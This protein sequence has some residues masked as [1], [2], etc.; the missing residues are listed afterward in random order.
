[1][2]YSSPFRNFPIC[3]PLGIAPDDSVA[4]LVNLFTMTANGQPIKDAAAIVTSDLEYP[5]SGTLHCSWNS[6]L[7]YFVTGVQGRGVQDAI[8]GVDRISGTTVFK[9]EMPAGIYTDNLMYDYTTDALYYFAFNI[10]Q[11]PPT[12]AIVK[13]DA[14]TGNITYIFDVSREIKGFVYGGDVTICPTTGQIFVGVD[15]EANDGGFNDYIVEF[16]VTGALPTIVGGRPLAF[17]V[18]SGMHAFCNA[19]GLQFLVGDTIQADSLDRETALVGQFLIPQDGKAPIV[20]VPFIS[21]RLPT[22]S[23]RGEIPLFLDSQFSEFQ[24]QVIIPMFPPFQ[25]GPGPAP[26]IIGGLVWTIDLT[27]RAAPQLAPINYYLVGAS[28]V[29]TV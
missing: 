14:A 23:Q 4:G 17:P 19:A 24:G 26:P 8:Y 27:R 5:K 3:R 18:P 29:P 12:A 10:Q 21:G 28:G 22:F 6:T 2:L 20:F 16:S 7:C 9:H 13:L 11:N 25:V 15:A 1:M